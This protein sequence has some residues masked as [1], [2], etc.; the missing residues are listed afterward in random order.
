MKFLIMDIKQ[1][2]SSY[3]LDINKI[4]MKKMINSFRLKDNYFGFSNVNELF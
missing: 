3:K 2:M 4:R 1:K